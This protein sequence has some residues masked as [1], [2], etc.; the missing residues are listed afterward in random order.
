LK[1]NID[2]VKNQ[3]YPDWEHIFID[4]FSQD[5]TLDMIKKYQQEFPDRVKLFKLYPKGISNAMNE[6]I[7]KS[8]GDYI[9]HLHSD[10]S[11]YDPNVLVDVN[12]FL[13]KQELDWVYGQINIVER[14]GTFV[15]VFPRKKI[16]K[17]KSQNYLGRYL[18][19][20]F[21]FIPHQAVFI[22]KKVFYDFGIFDENIKSAMDPDLWLRIKDKTRWSFFERIISNYCLRSDSQSAGLKYRE[23]NRENYYLV[24][25]RYLNKIEML[26]AGFINW[27][28][29]IKNRNYR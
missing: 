17:Q 11:F 4:G 19:K 16:W 13:N 1:K 23:N 25:S 21:N 9:I 10:D 20:F 5:G 6:G 15:G 3:K 26:L 29:E 8:V 27:L 14:D 22:K 7:K 2:S 28:L 18:L 12:D 24:Q